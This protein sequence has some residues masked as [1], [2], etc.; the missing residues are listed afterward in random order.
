[1]F[2]KPNLPYQANGVTTATSPYDQARK[3]ANSGYY[4]L[5]NDDTLPASMKAKIAKNGFT[6]KDS[7]DWY[8]SKLKTMIDNALTVLP[9]GKI[10]DASIAQAGNIINTQKIIAI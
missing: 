7:A 10:N 4:S 5:G 6:Q 9:L 2:Y 8:Y 3:I 1:M